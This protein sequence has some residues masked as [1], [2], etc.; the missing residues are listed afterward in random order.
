MCVLVWLE[1]GYGVGRGLGCVSTAYST[2]HGILLYREQLM[3]YYVCTNTG[4]LYEV[5]PAMPWAKEA[6]FSSG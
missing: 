5:M 1:S 4:L 2:C 6:R 3:C